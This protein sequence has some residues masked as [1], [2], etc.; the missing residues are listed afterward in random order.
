MDAETKPVIEPGLDLREREPLIP[1]HQSGDRTG[2][3]IVSLFSGKGG[4]GQS[5]LTANL[6][7]YLAQTGRRVLLVD[8]RRWGKN[9]HSFLGI[10]RPHADPRRAARRGRDEAG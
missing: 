8:A 7:V 1:R 6:G 9:L 4:V 5:M 10:P 3:Y 2:P